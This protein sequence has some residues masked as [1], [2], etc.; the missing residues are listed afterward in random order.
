MVIT[1]Q[2][3]IVAML[4]LTSNVATA[5]MVDGGFLTA[6]R[7]GNGGSYNIFGN[8]FAGH[9][10]IQQGGWFLF[11]NCSG[12]PGGTVSSINGAVSTGDVDGGHTFY[13]TGPSV[14]LTQG[15][16]FADFS[17]EGYFCQG[18]YANYCPL[19]LLPITGSGQVKIEVVVDSIPP[20]P[21]R[22]R[23]NSFTYTFNQTPEPSFTPM[24]ALG[25]VTL[26][27]IKRVRSRL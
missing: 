16:V 23:V 5:T 15:L 2:I 1:V 13:F 27:S 24:I 3:V 8:G 26:A 22:I 10:G 6:T 17:F 9:G 7:G 21:Y 12:C 25:L 14:I 20:D 4:L 19:G 18:A 11:I